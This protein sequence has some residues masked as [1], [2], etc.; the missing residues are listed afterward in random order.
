MAKNYGHTTINAC[1]FDLI[2]LCVMAFLIIISRGSPITLSDRSM[3]M[4]DHTQNSRMSQSFTYTLAKIP[5][6]LLNFS[7]CR[8]SEAMHYPV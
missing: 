1:S 6:L 8:C 4:M 5:I 7:Y 3:A 2:N